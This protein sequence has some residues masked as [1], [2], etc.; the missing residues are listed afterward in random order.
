MAQEMLDY[1]AIDGV[2][3]RTFKYEV[4]EC[5]ELTDDDDQEEEE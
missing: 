1:F 5:E 3:V 2:T 4:D